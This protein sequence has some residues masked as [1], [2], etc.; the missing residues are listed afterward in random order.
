MTVSPTS[1]PHVEG[2]RPSTAGL[3]GAGHGGVVSGRRL[4]GAFLLFSSF[5]W[6]LVQAAVAAGWRTPYSLSRNFISDLGAVHCAR[7]PS[8]TGPYV[9]SP[10]HSVMNV[11]IVLWGVTWAVGA[12]LTA[13]RGRLTGNVLLAV[14]GLG[15]V[16]V[17][18]WPEDTNLTIHAMGALIHT[19]I[20]GAGMAVIG[21]RRLRRGDIAG[22][23]LSILVF[24]TAVVGITATGLA[25]GSGSL[26]HVGLGV[27]ERIGIWP[28]A[29]W[30]TV[31]GVGTAWA[32][33]TRKGSAAARAS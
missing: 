12:L 5:Q 27:W 4:V 3:Q 20:G 25:A 31:A 18:V 32:A 29:A 16:L 21:F 30:L 23:V 7:F 24:V 10:A 17:G 33:V 22:G 6:F 14:G 13:E 15:T 26:L 1:V 11:S 19:V 8:G 9:C 28:Q 2:A